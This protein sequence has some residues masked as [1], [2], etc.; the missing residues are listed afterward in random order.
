MIFVA[1]HFGEWIQGLSG[2]AVGVVLVTL[3]CS[4][5]GV[6]AQRI[7]AG[8]FALDQE[9][10]ILAAGVA[11]RFLDALGRSVAD[12]TP[13]RAQAP[14]ALGYA[15]AHTGPARALISAPGAAP[16]GASAALRLAGFA[17]V[18]RFRTGGG[19]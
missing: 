14:D 9:P 17:G 8:G 13:T 10:A 7:G 12:P 3:A 11:R 18:L 5:L 1:G 16:Q 6:R 19:A 4:A 2:A 15:R